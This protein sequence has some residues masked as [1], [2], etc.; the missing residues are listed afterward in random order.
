MLGPNLTAGVEFFV[1]SWLDAKFGVEQTIPIGDHWLHFV[2]GPL[3]LVAAALIMRR[4]L[5][6]YGPW[7]AVLILAIVNELVDV[8]VALFTPEQSV[9]L[10]DSLSDVLMTISVPTVVLI[11]ARSWANPRK[12]ELGAAG[13]G[14]R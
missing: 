6:N 14:S 10:G 11:A 13:T 4:P 7:L 5:S 12:D 2:A 3:I 1:R 8:A 9:H